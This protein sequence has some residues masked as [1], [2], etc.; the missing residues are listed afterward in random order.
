MFDGV[1]VCVFFCKYFVRCCGVT[2]GLWRVCACR[3]LYWKWIYTFCG[4]NCCGCEKKG[5][6]T[7]TRCAAG[8]FACVWLHGGV[9]SIEC[10][11]IIIRCMMMG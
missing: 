7:R 5:D 2:K 11:S 1:C 8:V 3:F 10:S 4:W 9:S 6:I